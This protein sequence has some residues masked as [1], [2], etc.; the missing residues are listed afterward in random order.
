MVFCVGPLLRERNLADL[1]DTAEARQNLDI[2]RHQAVFEFNGDGEDIPVGLAAG[3]YVPFGC[4]IVRAVWLLP[5]GESGSITADV[6]VAAYEAW[7][8]SAGDSIVAASPP[9]V[10]SGVKSKD[11]ALTGWTRA[12]PEDSGMLVVV[13]ACTGVKRASL[14]LYLVET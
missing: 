12:V 4:T 7:P 8:P 11:D 9:T 2:G 5:P 10:V 6:R 14:Y 13:T 1:C 3:L